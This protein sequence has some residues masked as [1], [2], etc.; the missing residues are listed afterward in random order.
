MLKMNTTKRCYP[1]SD[2]SIVDCIVKLMYLHLNLISRRTSSLHCPVASVMNSE[3]NFD[4]SKNYRSSRLEQLS[5][6]TRKYSQNN[7]MEAHSTNIYLLTS[8]I[9][10]VKKVLNSLHQKDTLLLTLNIFHIFF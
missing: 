3:Q 9:D 4:C 1:C 10:T 2:I 7:F 8:T 5:I 6:K